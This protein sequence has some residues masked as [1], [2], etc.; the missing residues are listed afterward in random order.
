MAWDNGARFSY[1]RLVLEQ[2]QIHFAGLW[3]LGYRYYAVCPDLSGTT[4]TH[5]GKSL[6][7]W[8][9]TSCRT[10]TSPIEIVR[11]PPAGA[12]PAAMRTLD[13]MIEL[14]GAFRTTRD[15]F[16]DLH[17]AL[18]SAFP[19]FVL[20]ESNAHHRTAVV[21]VART[22]SDDENAKL[23][24]AFQAVGLPFSLTVR[25]NPSL[26]A[27]TAQFRHPVIPGFPMGDIDLLPS[28]RVPLSIARELRSLA[29]DDDDF[30]SAKRRTLLGSTELGAGEEVL[31]PSFSRNRTACLVNAAVFPPKNLR[32][33]L[34][35]YDV[36]HLVAPLADKLQEHLAA[37]NA[38]EPD[39]V[40]LLQ[41]GRLKILLP[42][43]L[44][45]YDLRWLGAV[46]EAAP[47]ALL[48]SRRLA[49][50]TVLDTRRRWPMFY[51][52]I[53]VDERAACLRVLAKAVDEAPP[54]IKV[55]LSSFLETLSSAWLTSELQVTHQ[56]AMGTS[57]CGVPAL[58]A[59]LVHRVRGH[60]AR[61]EFW[62]AG[63]D[64]EWAA[65]LGASVCPKGA[66]SYSEDGFVELIASLFSV[67]GNERVVAVAPETFIALDGILAVDNDVPL[68]P[69]ATELASHD[70]ERLREEMRRIAAWNLDADHLR[71]AIEKFNAEVRRYE[72]KADRLR[73]LNVA[74]F[75]ASVGTA[76]ALAGSEALRHTV[77]PFA[78]LG[79]ALAAGLF[80][81]ARENMTAASPSLSAAM[82]Y[83]NACLG[84][85]RPEAV[86]VSRLRKELKILKG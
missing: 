47:Q 6:V 74:G 34:T 30:W 84:G 80:H 42:Q 64:V 83:A 58:A 67:H 65:A 50:A 85:V 21:E 36:V 68:V 38:S 40:G 27:D 41:C 31:P 59:N 72:H 63:M 5:D 9:N 17:L 35:L 66:D 3:Q 54:E 76:V 53:G 52:P 7:D 44:D 57:V 18:T 2:P 28:R 4:E 12:V 75:A 61:L 46:A 71:D 16:L 79:A 25:V 60:D 73:T 55:L 77:G 8:F 56:G 69:F 20:A 29:E 37:L 15:V 78:S 23:H 45:R 32:S 70:I 11:E 62:S 51:A 10:M 43:G 86:L 48:L 81:M 24:A 82:D 1:E 39:L 13:E 19:N 26:H 14:R 49:A 22:L 33:Y